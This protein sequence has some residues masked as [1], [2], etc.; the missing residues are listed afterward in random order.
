FACGRDGQAVRW[1]C[2]AVVG[3]AVPGQRLERE[4]APETPLP[5]PHSWL[6][7]GLVLGLVASSKLSGVYWVAAAL[8]AA[9]VAEWPRAPLSRAAVL[10]LPTVTRRRI[11]AHVT[12]RHTAH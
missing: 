8:F 9:R 10:A 4:G 3:A 12:P 5:H 6:A 7:L 11:P 1:R 2:S